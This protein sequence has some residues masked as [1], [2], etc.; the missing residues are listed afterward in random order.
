MRLQNQRL[1]GTKDN[2]EDKVHLDGKWQHQEK[3]LFGVAEELVIL[4][5]NWGLFM[6]SHQALL[7]HMEVASHPYRT[8]SNASKVSMFAER[9]TEEPHHLRSCALRQEC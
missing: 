8:P 6:L 3:Q 9:S 1:D 5:L 7:Q 2:P 4:L